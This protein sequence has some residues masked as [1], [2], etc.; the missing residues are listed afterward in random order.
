MALGYLAGKASAKPFSLKVNVPLLMVLSILPDVD[1]LAGITNFHRGPTHSL[2][3]ATLVF[4]PV[5]LIYHKKALPYFLALVSHS[6][7]DLLIGGNLQLFWPLITKPIYIP[8]PFPIIAITS[9]LNVAIETTLFAI[10]IAILFLTKD[11][12]QFLKKKLT[13]LTL[14]IPIT[15]VLLP[16]FLAY[17]LE[18]P[19][20]LILPHLF[21]LILFVIAIARLALV[22]PR[23][24]RVRSTLL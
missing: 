19:A 11:Y 10:T 24:P 9:S 4:I 15:T 22:R 12:K 1:I 18:V 20:I 23:K 2:I 5:F 17:P 13:N 3:T 8:K 6:L 21:Y 16:T 7:A 14:I